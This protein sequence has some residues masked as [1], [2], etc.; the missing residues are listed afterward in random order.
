MV[1]NTI[2]IF[3]APAGSF[4][5]MPENGSRKHWEIRLTTDSGQFE[6]LLVSDEQDV[7]GDVLEFLDE[8]ITSMNSTHMTSSSSEKHALSTELIGSHS[9]DSNILTE[10]LTNESSTLSPEATMTS[11]FNNSRTHLSMDPILS[12]EGFRRLELPTLTPYVLTGMDEP[13]SFFP[14][15]EV[16]GDQIENTHQ[17]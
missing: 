2:L 5:E 11:P 16:F 14:I 13:L 4:V 3:R 15:S 6:V 8:P 10:L 17:L 12:R 1:D 7:I 9:Y